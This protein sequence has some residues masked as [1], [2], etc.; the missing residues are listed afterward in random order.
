[1]PVC[2]THANCRSYF[3]HLWC[4]NSL[5][6]LQI[7]SPCPHDVVFVSFVAIAASLHHTCKLQGIIFIFLMPQ[8]TSRLTIFQKYASRYCGKHIFAKR[9]LALPIEQITQIC[10][11]NTTCKICRMNVL[12]TS[13]SCKS[14]ISHCMLPFAN[15]QLHAEHEL[16]GGGVPSP[17]ALQ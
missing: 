16:K 9:M 17:E 11:A 10:I 2:I 3:S 4:S 5:V 7:L 14:P 13:S 15:L 1:M 12:M 6:D 8:L